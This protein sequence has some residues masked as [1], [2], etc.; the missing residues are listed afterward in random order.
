MEPGEE[1]FLRLKAEKETAEQSQ[2]SMNTLQNALIAGAKKMVSEIY[3]HQLMNMESEGFREI[4]ERI[5]RHMVSLSM[6]ISN[7]VAR[8]MVKK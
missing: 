7:I 4:E 1:D 2:D 3:E 8:N 6:E 5:A